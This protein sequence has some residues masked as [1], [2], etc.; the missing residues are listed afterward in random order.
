MNTPVVAPN[1][2]LKC[3]IMGISK[4]NP[5]LV[6]ARSELFQNVVKKTLADRLWPEVFLAQLKEAGASSMEAK[7]MLRNPRLLLAEH[8][9]FVN[10]DDN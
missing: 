7:N 6:Q 8:D 1:S 10:E 3:L 2:H 5:S 9:M 4:T